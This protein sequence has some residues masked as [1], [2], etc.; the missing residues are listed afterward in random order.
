MAKLLQEMLPEAPRSP[1]YLSDKYNPDDFDQALSGTP[2]QNLPPPPEVAPQQQPQQPEEPSRFRRNLGEAAHGLGNMAFSTGASLLGGYF[3]QRYNNPAAQQAFN[4]LGSSYEQRMNMRWFARQAEIFSKGPGT[5]F[6]ETMK[7]AQQKFTALTTPVAMPQDPNN[8]PDPS[9]PQSATGLPQYSPDGTMTGVVPLNS[10][11][12][13]NILLRERGEFYQTY[14]DASTEYLNQAGQFPGNPIISKS[15]ESIFNTTIEMMNKIT[16][17][18]KEVLAEQT[19]ERT[20][21][22]AGLELNS[23]KRD[24]R[25]QLSDTDVREAQ[26]MALKKAELENREAKSR[27]WKN[28]NPGE[29]GEKKQQDSFSPTAAVLLLQTDANYNQALTT[30]TAELATKM[31]DQL[32]NAKPKKMTQE[33]F[34][35]IIETDARLFAMNQMIRQ[36]IA[37]KSVKTK[38]NTTEAEILMSMDPTTKQYS[39]LDYIVRSKVVATDPDIDDQIEAMDFLKEFENDPA[40]FFKE[41]MMRTAAAQ[42]ANKV[43]Q[44]EEKKPMSLLDKVRHN[45]QVA[46]NRR[47]TEAKK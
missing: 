36:L 33:K 19:A 7:Q 47:E 22:K 42:N 38:V 46:K 9:Q 32:V 45:A 31:K 10:P 24:E 4:R 43:N 39:L 44:P 1:G 5:K 21:E 34:D 30:A 26:R 14:A 6:S 35:K 25:L 13:Q 17:G 41:I 11:E 37:A 27:I 20:N 12:S 16:G 8:P 40:G 29:V 23:A 15:A 2:N 3:A 18:R 28:Y